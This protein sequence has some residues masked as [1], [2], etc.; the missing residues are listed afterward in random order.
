MD[1][2]FGTRRGGSFG[3]DGKWWWCRPKR[4]SVALALGR[5][6]SQGRYLPTWPGEFRVRPDC[7]LSFILTRANNQMQHE[8]RPKYVEAVTY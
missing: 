8:A 6:G 4:C 5:W 3:G 1:P 7:P 2:V